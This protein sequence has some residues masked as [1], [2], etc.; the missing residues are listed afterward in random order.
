[1]LNPLK[2]AFIAVLI[3]P[4]LALSQD[5]N[6]TS[7]PRPLLWLM[8]QA[9]LWTPDANLT[10]ECRAQIE[11]KDMKSNPCETKTELNIW[12]SF[13]SKIF[14][15]YVPDE[16]VGFEKIDFELS[17]EVKVRGLLGLHK[18]QTKPLVIFRMGIYGNRDEPLAERFILKL[19]FQELGYNVLALESLTSH[20]HIKS[21]NKVSIGGFE[22]G[23]H[24]FFIL[25]Q[26]KQKKWDWTKN[27]SDIHLVALSMGGLGAYLTTYLD[28][29]TNHQLKSALFF[30]PLMDFKAT[31]DNLEKPSLFDAGADLWSSWRFHAFN[32]KNPELNKVEMWRMLFDWKPRYNPAV[33]KWLSQE[34]KNPRLTLADFKTNFPEL[35]IPSIVEKHISQS[36]NFYDLNNFW[37]FF[38]NE[39]T[40]IKVLMTEVDPLVPPRLNAGRID[41]KQIPGVFARTQVDYMKGMHCALAEAYQWP[42]LI[43]YV[44]RSLE[45]K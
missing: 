43:E 21:N 14:F 36:K 35:K 10:A 29:Q 23:L 40:P 5:K 32:E 39:K 24:T 13:R 1:M 8:N 45:A 25:N 41:S 26:I 11:S 19:L 42:Y 27:I 3:L 20:G 9:P 2:F 31:Q 30:C 44:K 17:P 28:E 38:R 15:N 6:L 33:M 22:E 37:T 4:C 7:Y 16:S 34:A 18:N 12:D